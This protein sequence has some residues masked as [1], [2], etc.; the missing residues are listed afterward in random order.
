MSVESWENLISPDIE[1]DFRKAMR[2]VAASVTLITARDDEGGFVGLA[3]TSVCPL[4]M[5]P[6]SILIAVNRQASA[7]P[8]IASTGLFC[9]NYLRAGQEDILAPFSNAARR[10]ERFASSGWYEG[11]Q[12]LP[13]FLPA[14]SN[15]FCAVDR[16]I[17]HCTHTVFCGR[18]VDIRMKVLDDPDP[19]LWLNGGTTEASQSPTNT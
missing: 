7:Y 4:S 3:M 2:T 9:V 11:C 5:D 13:Y 19:L 8:V 15:A 17:D 12:R 18:V 1:I 6:P 10:S 14:L 16:T